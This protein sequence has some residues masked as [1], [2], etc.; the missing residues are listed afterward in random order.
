VAIPFSYNVRNLI[1][2]RV[3]TVATAIGIGLVVAIFILVLA[4]AHGFAYAVQTAGSDRNAIVLRKGATA[5]I[6]SGVLRDEAQSLAVR[7]EIARDEQG[8][9]LVVPE[10]VVLVV[11]PRK[12]DAKAN[13]V[14]RGTGDNVLGVRPTAKLSA[15]GRM[16]RPGLPEIVV[17][18]ALSERMKNLALGDTIIFAKRDWSVVGIFDTGGTGF[19][20]E[21]WA[22]VEQ[23]Q[24][25]FRREAVFQSLTFRMA[26][27]SGLG[28]LQAEIES[29]PK[30]QV[31]LKTEAD[32]Y[33]EQAGATS[34][35]IGI[36]GTLVTLIMSVGAVVGA[37]NTMYAAV[38][39]RGREIATL[40]SLGFRRRSV[41][42]S[43]M[44][45][46]LLLAA[47]GGILGCL[48][49]LPINGISTGT[50]N[51]DTFSELSFAFRVTPRILA[52]GIA[53]SLF[54]GIA[55]GLL[56]AVRAARLPITVGLRQI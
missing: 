41:L 19:E 15:G 56:P 22:D 7:P 32:Y 17:G 1:V 50:T 31:Q 38:G 37:M 10:V 21:I 40:R 55:G 16:F 47:A 45:E 4:L 42:A 33:S 43:F 34:T 48:F 35:M 52:A 18:R 8:R 44:A 6:T 23:V 9:P 11:L 14:V 30:Y 39:S 24:A 53:F 25:A 12:D 2:R 51:W 13:V 5:E 36:L 29:D 27:P 49:A 54:M 3:S 28:A 26:D 20:S 46:S